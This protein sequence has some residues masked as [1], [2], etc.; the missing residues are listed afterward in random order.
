MSSEKLFTPPPVKPRSWFD[1]LTIPSEVEGLERGWRAILGYFSPKLRAL[2]RKAGFNF[3]EVVIAIM[4]LSTLAIAAVPNFK[5]AKV[6]KETFECVENLKAI[7][8]AKGEWA[9]ET[10]AGN[11]APLPTDLSEIDAYIKG[12]SPVCPSGGT[13]TY[14]PIGV[15]PQC[16]LAIGLDGKPNTPDDHILREAEPTVSPKQ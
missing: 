5:K 8:F 7:A 2:V 10:G 12:G 3:I 16:S 14:N 13:Y 6:L 1:K 4:I 15:N 9:M 11:G